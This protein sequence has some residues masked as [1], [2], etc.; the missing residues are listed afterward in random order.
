MQA[1]PES[2]A[3]REVVLTRVIDAPARL[4]F[5]AY[6]KPE[7]VKQW[8]GPPGYP[9]TMCE[10]DFRKGGK[11]RFSMASGAPFGGT[12][13]DIVP[14]QR[15]AYDNAFEVVPPGMPPDVAGTM[16][17]TV[18]FD[19]LKDGKTLLTI[20]TVFETVAMK[21]AHCALGYENGLGS[22]IPQLEATAHAIG[23]AEGAR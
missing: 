7:H 23:A 6:T 9:L 12:Y 17:V 1:R 19:E 18:T 22:T 4:L 20:R 14:N 13:L 2:A 5:L 10:M 8:F 3:D 21:N 15:I 11:F 16:V